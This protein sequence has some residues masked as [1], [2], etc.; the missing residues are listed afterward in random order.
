VQVGFYGFSQRDD[1]SFNLVF[2]D[3]S[4]DPVAARETSSGSLASVFAQDSVHATS[5]L[6]V[7]AGVRQT[8][9]AGA[10]VENATSPRLGASA[11]VPSLGWTVRGFYGW[12]YQAPP[13]VTV[14]GPLLEFVTNQNL[15]LIP[16]RGER[17]REYQVGVMIPVRGWTVDADMFR[18][19]ATNYFDHNSVG[20][21]NV[22]F[23][24]TIDGALIRGMELTVRSPRAWRVVSVHVAYA[25]QIAEGIGAV[26]GGLTDFS[27]AD[28]RFLL[29][30]D[31]RHTL[32]AGLN[33]AL[34]HGVA[35]GATVYYG[36]G[37]PDDDG[38][39]RLAPQASLDLMASKAL[40]EKLALSLTA[41]NVTDRHVLLDNSLTFGGTHFNNPREIFAEVRYR[42]HY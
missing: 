9:F 23:P 26:S 1:Q 27:A 22:F 19:S 31:Q 39:A 33:A 38:P 17:D 35:A 36:S 41:L 14:S 8:R 10:L 20:N 24:L 13:L 18:T 37:F 25:N 28:G 32:S 7:T 2:N 12:F 11:R 21:S 4:S 30:H 16:L 15:A 3:G 5:W 34:P 6:T 29:D 40:G 42:F